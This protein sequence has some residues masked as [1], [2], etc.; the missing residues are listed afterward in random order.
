MFRSNQYCSRYEETAIQ[1]DTPLIFPGDNARQNKNGYQFTINDR[2]SYFDWFN[3][4]FEVKF[5]VNQLDGGGGYAG[6]GAP[7][8]ATMINGSTSLINN[9]NIKQ[10]GKV[11]YDGN[12]LFLT[13]HVKSLIEYSGD[14]ARSI[15]TDE[16]FYV[17]ITNTA[18][19]DNNYG[20]SERLDATKDEKEVSCIIPL[21]RYSFFKSLETNMLPPSQIQINVTL[22]DDNIL[23]YK[24]DASEVGRVV[25]RKFVLW[26][27]RMIYNS[28]GLSYVM[29]NYMIPTNWTYLREMV[30]TLNNIKHVDNNFRISP[31]ILNP[32]YVFVF[33]QRS[34]KMNSQDNNS[35]LFDTFKLNA[36]DNNC[37]LQSARL[38][39][40]N[41]IYYPEIEY[42]YD[43][44]ARIF[45]AVNNY[46]Y[47]QNDKNTGSLLTLKNFRDLYGMLFFNISYKN[48]TDNI[49]NDPKEIILNY[50]L[51]VA[52]TDPYT[53]Y[54]IVLYEQT[55]KVDVLGNE[56]ILYT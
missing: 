7:T 30:Q 33:F 31:S 8:N 56:L 19:K 41:G 29:K 22:T 52:S 44:I 47:K 24:T 4:F 10:N 13:T 17:D 46:A 36:A 3:G 28:T 34:D 39:V 50:K 14:Y 16:F 25:I 35:Y 42:S 51:S 32:K 2:S 45:K 40:G 49:T 38:S 1:L 26:I 21:N 48:E 20:F 27:P 53:I 5:I 15:A 43:S 55:V 11:V 37:H 6:T 23:I 54:S 12:N 9:L 18:S